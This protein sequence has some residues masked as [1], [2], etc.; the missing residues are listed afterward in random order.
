MLTASSTVSANVNG[1]SESN[2]NDDF[3]INKVRQD[4][5]GSFE[6]ISDEIIKNED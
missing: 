5:E 1:K 4:D 6:D 2:S 3:L